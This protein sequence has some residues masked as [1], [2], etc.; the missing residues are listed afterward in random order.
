MLRSHFRWQ[1][2]TAHIPQ[3]IAWKYLSLIKGF[4]NLINR[5][6]IYITE[7]IILSYYEAGFNK[8]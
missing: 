5:L 4:D 6:S 3:I 1:Y 2:Y 7:F 8:V